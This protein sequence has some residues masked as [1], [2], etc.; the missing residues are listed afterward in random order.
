MAI[1]IHNNHI[2]N[3]YNLYQ[4]T[5]DVYKKNT[6]ET[7]NTPDN[8]TSPINQTVTSYAD[9]DLKS[10][11]SNDEKRVLKEIFGDLT[12]DKE[13]SVLYNSINSKELLKG[14]KIDIRL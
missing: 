9:Q 13:T 2:E 1:T 11:L 14:S 4:R 10:F 3:S 12:V 5:T 6:K 7:A 8:Q